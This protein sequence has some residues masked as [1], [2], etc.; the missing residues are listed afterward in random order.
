MKSLKISHPNLYNGK[1]I[2][3]FYSV[4]DEEFKAQIEEILDLEHYKYQKTEGGVYID[5]GANCGLAT[6]YFSQFSKKVYSLEPSPEIYKALELNAKNL[7]NVETFN[8]AWANGTGRDFFYTSDPKFLPQTFS[9]RGI[10]DKSHAVAVDCITPNEFFANNK[11]KHVDVLKVDIEESEYLI[12]PD[13]QF[14]E[15]TPK[16]DNII[17]EAHSSTDGGFPEIIP[18]ILEEWGYKTVYPKLAKPN[19][20]RFLVSKDIKTGEEKKYVYQMETIFVAT[21]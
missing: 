18:V 10:S 19:Y 16:I 5:L 11:I 15:V 13:P 4:T 7:P 6:L 2:E 9:D 12:F 8:L 1:E 3:V 14:G 20:S 17:G 21:K